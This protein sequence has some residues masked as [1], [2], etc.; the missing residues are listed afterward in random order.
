MF[1]E[2]RLNEQQGKHICKYCGKSPKSISEHIK[3]AHATEANLI[4]CKI[5]DL[6][7]FKVAF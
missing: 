4:S 6:N 2:I 1:Q 3:R 5:C 7:F